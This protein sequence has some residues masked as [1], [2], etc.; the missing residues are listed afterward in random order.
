MA[1]HLAFDVNE[2]DEGTSLL[3]AGEIDLGTVSLLER[4]V[5]SV[6]IGPPRCLSLDLSAVTFCD[7]TGVAALFRARAAATA[8]GWSFQVG[9]ASG[10]VHRV[11]STVGALDALNAR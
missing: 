4:K 8:A 5:H 7:S 10:I 11:L 9:G 1:P 6:L 2:C 3:V